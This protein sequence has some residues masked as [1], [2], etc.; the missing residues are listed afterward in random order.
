M[1]ALPRG[2][3][4]KEQLSQIPGITSSRTNILPS[5]SS[6]T[7]KYSPGGNSRVVFNIPSFENSY[8][9]CARSYVSFKI[10]ATGTD[11]ES[12]IL[13]D[14]CPVFKALMLKNS[15][16]TVIEDIQSYDVLCKIKSNMETKADKMAKAISHR[17]LRVLKGDH[18]HADMTDYNVTA[19]TV[20]HTL[21]S[22][23]LG[24]NQKYLVPVSS[25]SA[26][27]GYAFSL[28][29]WLNDVSKVFGGTRSATTTHAYEITDVSFD[30]ELVHVTDSIMANINSEIQ[31]GASIPMPFTSYRAH[32]THI[33][34]GNSAI[35]NIS[36]SAHDVTAVYT[37]LKPQTFN[38][39]PNLDNKKQLKSSNNPYRFL[40]GRHNISTNVAGDA[41]SVGSS[42]TKLTRYAYRYGSKYYP[43]APVTMTNDSMLALE[44]IVSGFELQ[45]RLPF[46]SDTMIIGDQVVSR[47]ETD[48]FMI[49][50]SFK[51]T[52]DAIQNG[53]NSSA[54]GAAIQI[55]LTFA[56]TVSNIEV[57]SFV[58]S[59]NV[60]YISK[61]GSSGLVVN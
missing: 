3:V 39:E 56:G 13:T 41:L 16:S 18:Q 50:Q 4:S 1:A 24:R 36:E 20:I 45:D 60:L 33:A 61:N 9:N 42:N 10:R 30:I 8:I 25:M 31:A 5:N 35:V 43:L 40:G 12:A 44:N 57:T 22:G 15:R 55:D 49:A 47:F 54:T 32:T 21:E 27:S 34:S 48:T 19:K 6:G 37:V 26:S 59:S 51:A 14:G 58:E 7:F 53:L 17:D 2:L 28:E 52:N 23:M 29:L 46:M 38:I 11:P